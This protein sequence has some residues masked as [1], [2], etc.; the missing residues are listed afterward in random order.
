MQYL[1][2]DLFITVMESGN[3]S[4]IPSLFCIKK[5]YRYVNWISL[6]L[7]VTSTNN[8][9]PSIPP[10]PRY[11]YIYTLI[12]ILITLID[13]NSNVLKFLQPQSDIITFHI[14]LRKILIPDRENFFN[15]REIK[16]ILTPS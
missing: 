5:K 9:S 11:V 3:V 8:L 7:L 16:V 2:I 1:F 15:T 13:F 12:Y 4:S 14:M 10:P 6:Q